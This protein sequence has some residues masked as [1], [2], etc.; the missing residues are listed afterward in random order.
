M[1]GLSEWEENYPGNFY[2]IHWFLRWEIEN[3]KYIRWNYNGK[4]VLYSDYDR[5]DGIHVPL[6]KL[7]YI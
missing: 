7:Q 1:K 2:T 6:Q 3:Y 4:I 5:W